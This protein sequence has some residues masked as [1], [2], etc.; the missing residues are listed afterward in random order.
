MLGDQI[1]PVYFCHNRADTGRGAGEGT[2]GVT[3]DGGD[4]VGDEEGKGGGDVGDGGDGA[5]DAEQLA[6]EASDAPNLDVNQTRCAASEVYWRQR[7]GE[8]GAGATAEGA[9]AEGATTNGGTA[10]GATVEGAAQGQALW[11]YEWSQVSANGVAYDL[12]KV[13]GARGS[14]FPGID[15]AP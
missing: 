3:G 5:E 7:V 10:N 8:G 11:E 4:E 2:V 12:S 1:W 6:A 9:T 15:A 14:D 13:P